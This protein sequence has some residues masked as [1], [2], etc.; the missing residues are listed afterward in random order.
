MTMVGFDSLVPLVTPSL[1]LMLSW[2]MPLSLHASLSARSID[3]TQD[4]RGKKFKWHSIIEHTVA[5]NIEVCP[6]NH[7]SKIHEIGKINTSSRKPH[8]IEKVLDFH[9]KKVKDSKQLKAFLYREIG[10]CM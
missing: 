10:A 1:H 2:P 8:S 6:Q 3:W 7:W 4:N 5:S 9:K